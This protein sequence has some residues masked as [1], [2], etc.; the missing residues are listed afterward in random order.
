MFSTAYAVAHTSAAAA[1]DDATSLQVHSGD[2]VPSCDYSHLCSLRQRE[3]ALR[4]QERL[5][6]QIECE[7]RLSADRS[8]HETETERF[9]LEISLRR[10]EIERQIIRDEIMNRRHDSSSA[11]LREVR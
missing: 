7:Q 3:L 11:R 5:D 10:A 8:R 9:N 2:F 4:E 1:C 6:R